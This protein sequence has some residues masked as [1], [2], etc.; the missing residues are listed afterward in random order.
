MATPT[1]WLAEGGPERSQWY[2]D[3]FRSL[4]AD[5]ADLVGEARFMDALLPPGSRVLDAGCGPGRVAA[6]LHERGHT[7]VGVDIDEALITAAVEDHPGPTFVVAD[8]AELD[9]A[10]AGIDEQFAG[11]VLAGNVMT[12]VAP[13]SES[14]VLRSVANHVVPDGAVVVGF[15]LDRGY[16]LDRFDRDV[17]KA[18]LVQEGRFATWDLR[19][20]TQE[21]D[22]A[23]TVL[24][25][26]QLA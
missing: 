17:T 1:R 2:I 11:A 24:R 14:A 21:S 19:P 15:G 3:R 12:Y 4:A 10:A 9:L 23:V 16:P 22:F 8:L 26:P 7:V 25:V 20:W 6:G 5:G 13:G 18:G